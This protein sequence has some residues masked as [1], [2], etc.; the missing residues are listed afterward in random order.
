MPGKHINHLETRSSNLIDAV[1]IEGTLKDAQYWHQNVHL[2][3]IAKSQDFRLDR[4]W[5]WPRLVRWLNLLEL[6]AGRNTGFFQI[7][8]NTAQG[9]AFPV[10]QI[11]VSDGFPFFPGQRQESI[12]LWFLAA[13]PPSALLAQGLP[14]DLKLMRALVD[15]AIQFSFQR[16]YDGRLTL[17]AA[18]SGNEASD[19][20]LFEKY[21]KGVGL[22]LYAERSRFIS[23]SRRN[24][25]RYFYADENRPLDLTARLDY[26]R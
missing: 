21:E 10:G 11:F 4:N 20:D 19:K 14:A 2:P 25:A 22:I 12:F 13:A 9:Y 23:P 8:V 26:L 17:H 3:H 18:G 16:G 15:V 5:N 1:V 24:D 7:N 6:L